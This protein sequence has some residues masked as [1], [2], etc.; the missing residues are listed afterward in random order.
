MMDEIY[1]EAQPLSAPSDPD[2]VEHMKTRKRSSVLV[3]IEDRS[4]PVAVT[5]AEVIAEIK[6][7]I[8]LRHSFYYKNPAL[9]DRLGELLT[10]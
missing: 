1:F 2:M 4:Q 8:S 7:Q 9:V 10:S 3:E 6:K 5:L